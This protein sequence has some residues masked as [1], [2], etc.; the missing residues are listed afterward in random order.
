MKKKLAIAAAIALMAVSF[1]ACG[2]SS[3]NNV[4]SSDTKDSSV[5]TETVSGENATSA[6]NEQSDSNSDKETEKD[7]SESDKTDD[8]DKTDKNGSFEGMS[9]QP[10]KEIQ[11]DDAYLAKILDLT[12]KPTCGVDGSA[13]EDKFV[14]LWECDVAV[15][16]DTAYSGIFGVPLYASDRIEIKSDKTG[17]I[18]ST[19]GGKDGYVST[20]K[21]FTWSVADGTLTADI[22]G[23]TGNVY[24]AAMH[25]SDDGRLML[26]SKSREG[27]DVFAYYKNVE[28]FTDFDFGSVHFDY[29]SL[30]E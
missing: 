8:S 27:S 7:S 13:A 28:S 12:D 5:A 16:G 18:V 17:S 19:T 6:N 10:I 26:I 1:A 30:G 3:K 4:S 23:E 15:N 20:A 21:D 2:N 11:M 24:S 14:G 25:M 22:K 9:E 29:T